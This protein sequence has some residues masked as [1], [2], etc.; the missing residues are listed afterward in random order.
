MKYLISLMLFIAATSMSYAQRQ[1][2]IE[3]DA[4]GNVVK[5]YT[6]Q[7]TESTNLDNQYAIKVYP[8]PTTGPVKIKVYEG[9]SGYPVS[10]N[11]QLVVQ[12]VSGYSP[13]INRTFTNGDI[14]IDLSSAPNGTYVLYFRVY[15]NPQQPITNGAI[16]IIKQS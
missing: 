7:K 3:Y 5:Q 13:V 16:K 6:P 12:S 9:R 14:Q 2:K 1:V 4:A 11:V 10:C 15:L 8:N